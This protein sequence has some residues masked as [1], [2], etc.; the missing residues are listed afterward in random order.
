MCRVERGNVRAKH[1]P[2]FKNEHLSESAVQTV[3]VFLAW[4]VSCL[5]LRR[6]RFLGFLFI[7]P[8]LWASCL[9]DYWSLKLRAQTGEGTQVLS[10]AIS[11]LMQGKFA[12]CKDIKIIGG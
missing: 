9:L 2:D 6:L 12:G 3:F 4:R 7:F 11:F 1:I 8:F 5:S 10:W